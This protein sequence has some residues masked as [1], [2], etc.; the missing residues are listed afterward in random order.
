[1]FGRDM[2]RFVTVFFV[3]VSLK[4]CAILHSLRCVDQAAETKVT[5]VL[6]AFAKL[7]RN[8]G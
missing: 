1:M 3:F 5:I 6:N 8:F 7:V 4:K 2:T